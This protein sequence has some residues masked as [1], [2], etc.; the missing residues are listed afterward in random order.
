M[1][2]LDLQHG[3]KHPVL[4]VLHQEHSTPGRIGR[5]LEARGHRLDIRRP[6]FGDPLPK[7]LRHHA[8]AIYFGGPMS[9]TD[10]DDFVT[11]EIDWIGVP[12]REDK[13]YLGICLGAQMLARHLGEPIKSHPRGCVER[14]YY[15]IEATPAGR[16]LCKPAFPEFVY[17][18]H[19]EGFDLPRGATLLAR[20]EVFPTQAFGYGEAAFGLQFHPDVTFAMLCRWTTKAAAQLLDPGA[21]PLEDHRAGWY[22]FDA[23]MDRW[24]GA[25]LD[26]WLA[27]GVR[28]HGQARAA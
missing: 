22:Q 24:I 13:P 4:V 27:G 6:R 11:R 10:T 1:I 28:R 14:G 18:W 2:E 7:S 20:G 23:A 21:H 12:L 8:G 3:A 5:L 26:R 19:R 17:Q 15:R 9:A 25:F 16:A